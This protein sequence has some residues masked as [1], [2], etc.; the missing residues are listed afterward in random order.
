MASI[1]DLIRTGWDWLKD[2]IRKVWARFKALLVKVANWSE[3]VVGE[4]RDLIK[5]G[6]LKNKLKLFLVRTPKDP[7]KEAYEK[8]KNQGKLTIKTLSVSGVMDN[9]A[10]NNEVVHLVSADSNNNTENVT[11]IWSNEM[12]D[13][14]RDAFAGNQVVEIQLTD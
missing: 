12:S 14:L 3:T 10:R 1:F 9:E 11:S 6:K 2:A 5:S 4:I 13:D 7:F 8:A